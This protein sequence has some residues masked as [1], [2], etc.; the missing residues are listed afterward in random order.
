MGYNFHIVLKYFLAFVLLLTG[1]ILVTS[2]YEKHAQDAAAERQKGSQSAVT[3]TDSEQ[4]AADA[5]QA[6][7]DHPR[8]YL[9]YQVFGWPNGVTVWALFLTLLTI[10]D[11]TRHTARAAQASEAAIAVALKQAEHTVNSER[12]WV[13]AELRFEHGGGLSTGSHGE[14]WPE[15]SMATVIVS[16]KNAGSTPAWV[17]EQFVHLEESPRILTSLEKY[18]SPNFPFIGE[19]KTSNVNYQIHPLTPG[20]DP[21]GWRAWVFDDGVP[22]PENG[23][24][25]YI[26]GVVRYRDAFDT[27]RETYFGYSVKGDKRLE[28]IPNE[29]YNK[30]T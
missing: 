24:H 19:G 25:V 15:Q 23:L 22:T 16:I 20:D 8:W 9:A 13:M 6:Q 14:G 12:A 29:A 5:E 3:S 4:A 1:S 27:K 26:Y 7:R 28:R 18:E 10:A 17:Y 21:I 2:Q 11:Q 30:H